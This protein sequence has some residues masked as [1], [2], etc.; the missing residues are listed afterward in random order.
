MRALPYFP[1]FT[2]GRS[3]VGCAGCA[4]KCLAKF[5]G[6]WAFAAVISSYSS[7]MVKGGRASG[8]GEERAHF[9]CI[10]ALA[11]RRRDLLPQPMFMSSS[12][13]P[14]LA[15][16]ALQKKTDRWFAAKAG[17]TLQ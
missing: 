15:S 16:L 12:L 8:Q 10:A 7:A 4:S 9:H 6:C 5:G 17:R 14:Q 3:Y 1:S 11:A 13:C 2:F